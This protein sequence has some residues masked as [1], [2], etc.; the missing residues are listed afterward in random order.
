MYKIEDIFSA[1]T[2]KA[3]CRENFF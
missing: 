2:F 3:A 1:Q